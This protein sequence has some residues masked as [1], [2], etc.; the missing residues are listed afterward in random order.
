MMKTTKIFCIVLALVVMIQPLAAS[1]KS[2]D[3]APAP[4][5]YKNLFVFKTD[6]KFLG[7]TVEV[8]SAAGTVVTT[9]TLQ[10]RKMIIDFCDVKKG[11]YTIRVKKGDRVQEFQFEN[12]NMKK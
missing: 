3:L 9:Q 1:A 10:K 11:L 8:L 4:S 5:K 6:R 7:A 2:R 12:T